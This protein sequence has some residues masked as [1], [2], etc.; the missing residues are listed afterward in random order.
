M[1]GKKRNLIYGTFMCLF[2]SCGL[3][4]PQHVEVPS[5]TSIDPFRLDLILQKTGEKFSKTAYEDL[6]DINFRFIAW[7][8]AVY[9]R[10]N[11]IEAL[12]LLKASY[13]SLATIWDTCE[14]V[15]E[16]REGNTMTLCRTFYISIFNDQGSSLLDSGKVQFTLNRL[17]GN[18]WT[19]V[20]WQEGSTRSKFHP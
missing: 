9:T 3:F 14:G 19:I 16:I 17:S 10:E 5:G 13:D 2:L 7:D 6:F 1:A 12:K 8:N 20:Q 4:T 11:E 18:I 15:G